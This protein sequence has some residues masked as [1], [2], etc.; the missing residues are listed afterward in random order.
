MG[1]KK[2][3]S[4]TKICLRCGLNKTRLRSHLNRKNKCEAKYLDISPQCIL[5][6]YDKY[7]KEYCKIRDSN[8][9]F[10]KCG[11]SYTY[12]SGLSLYLY[13]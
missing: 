7:Y 8:K 12:N 3:K 13:L 4:N 9:F 10:C 11:K 1:Y 5:E 6:S 2:P